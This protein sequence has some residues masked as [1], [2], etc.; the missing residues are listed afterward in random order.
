[1][2]NKEELKASLKFIADKYPDDE[3]IFE[4]IESISDF[5]D[6]ERPEYDETDIIDDKGVKWREKYEDIR[7]KYRE[8]FFST[9]EEAKEDQKDDIEYDTESTEKTFEELFEERS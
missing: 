4:K 3:E 2:V 7:K 8:R 9:P 1:M 5:I 6:A